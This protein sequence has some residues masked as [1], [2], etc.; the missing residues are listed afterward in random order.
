MSD[1]NSQKWMLAFLFGVLFAIIS[2]P[3]AYFCTS[4]ISTSLGGIEF[5]RA[6]ETNYIG[7]LI[8]SIIFMLVIRIAL[9]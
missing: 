3:W 2:S 5:G 8:H 6:Y 1:D 7:L 4:Y 9:Y